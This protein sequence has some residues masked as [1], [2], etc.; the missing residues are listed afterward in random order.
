M[1][2]AIVTSCQSICIALLIFSWLW[3]WY[4]PSSLTT[5][6]KVNRV[7]PQNIELFHQWSYPLLVSKIFLL[8][9][10]FSQG[11]L[12]QAKGN[13]CS[14]RTLDWSERI[15]FFLIKKKSTHLLLCFCSFF[16]QKDSR[17]NW[18]LHM[19]PNPP[20]NKLNVHFS[21]HINCRTKFFYL[22]WL[23]ALLFHLLYSAHLWIPPHTVEE[24]QRSV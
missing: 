6:K 19:V 13:T 20:V 8:T 22:V 9:W 24:R 23:K 21:A 18:A 11:I 4:Q 1:K 16:R 17:G 7:F 14:D 5:S 10:G 3:Q 12:T 15:F 2:T